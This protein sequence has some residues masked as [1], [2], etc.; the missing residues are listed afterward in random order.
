[1][2]LLGAVRFRRHYYHCPGCGQGVSPLDQALGLTAADRTPAADEVVCLAGVP[3]SFAEAAEKTVPRA[4][5]LRVAEPTGAR[6]PEAAGARAGA[7]L[8]A[9]QTFGPPR[10]W[11]WHK[12]ADGKAVAY[13]SRD[14]T[15]VGQQGPGGVAAAG[16]RASVGMIYNP[17][18]DDRARRADPRGP[19]PAWPARYL[20]G[21]CP[22]AAR[23]E[24]R[25]R[26][27][28]QVGMDRAERGVALSDGGAGLEDFLRENS[29]RVE[30]VICD[31]DHVAE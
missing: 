8:A 4:A 20:A 5:G 29:P 18:P 26:Q 9:G 3:A 28:A 7:A 17:A 30:G 25:R 13:V 14:A 1:L 19:R 24:P 10:D 22:L 2:T 27:G 11:A 12:D 21:V 6:A 16:R 15:G 31:S 23:G